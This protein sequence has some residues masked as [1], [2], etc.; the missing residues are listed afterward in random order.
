MCVI[1]LIVEYRKHNTHAHMA[2]P[3]RIRGAFHSVAQI[4][5][6]S[7]VISPERL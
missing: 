4:V 7:H 3:V 5:D 2:Q 1:R 6:V